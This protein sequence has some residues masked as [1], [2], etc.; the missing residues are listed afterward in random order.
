MAVMEFDDEHFLIMA[1]RNG[2]V[3]KTVLSAYSRPLKGGIIAIKL[4][5]GDGLIDVR[6]VSKERRRLPRH[7]RRHVHS[8][9]RG[10][11]PR[12]GPQPR[13]ASKGS[14]SSAM[15]RSSAW[16]SP[17]QKRTLLTVCE[18]GYGKR[19]PIGP[20]EVGPEEPETDEE[21][22]G[23]ENDPEEE[24]AKYSGNM[25]YRRQNRGGKGL[26][27]IKTTKRNG[28]VIDV[29]AVADD[30]EVLMVTGFGKIQRLRARDI[31]QIGRNT[32]GVRII[33]LDEDDK[34]V[35]IARIPA[36]VVDET[37]IE[38]PAPEALPPSETGESPPAEPASEASEA[39][40][41]PAPESSEPPPEDESPE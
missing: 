12:H 39:S 29:L 30:D 37:E 22:E 11:R 33:R 3:K 20:G 18:N 25:R 32:Q 1:T 24:A 16:S 21:A 9:R 7:G 41:T 35:C 2:L 34:L 13:G 28:Q 40:E 17:S 23:D 5:E 38:G 36:E 14:D 27:D 31:S 19:T 26:R 15:T 10:G 6:I 4:D 8:L